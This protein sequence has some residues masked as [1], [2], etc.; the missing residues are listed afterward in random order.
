MYVTSYKSDNSHTT[1][2]IRD[3]GYDRSDN[4]TY[5]KPAPKSECK[6]G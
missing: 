5:R 1:D 4:Y 2:V 6:K 3:S